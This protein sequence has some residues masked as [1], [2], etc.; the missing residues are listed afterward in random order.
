ML[1]NLTGQTG[2]AHAS[3]WGTPCGQVKAVSNLGIFA[4]SSEIA[5]WVLKAFRSGRLQGHYFRL[6]AFV[7]FAGRAVGEGQV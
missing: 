2:K 5:S 3:T 1:F 4:L 6:R 7:P